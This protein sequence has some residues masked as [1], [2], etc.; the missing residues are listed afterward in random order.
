[1]SVFVRVHSHIAIYMGIVV[2][3]SSSSTWEAEEGGF[4]EFWASLVCTESSMFHAM[5]AT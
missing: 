5:K 2:H 1:M 3:T 4:S